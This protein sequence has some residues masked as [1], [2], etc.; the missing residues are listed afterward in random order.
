MNS[1]VN[2][3]IP[4]GSYET[5]SHGI[6]MTIRPGMTMGPDRPDAPVPGPGGPGAD[7]GEVGC[8]SDGDLVPRTREMAVDTIR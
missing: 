8:G 6:M 3:V 5:Y 1:T 2:V 7:C 4:Y